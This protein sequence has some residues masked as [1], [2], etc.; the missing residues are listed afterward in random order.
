MRHNLRFDRHG[1]LVADRAGRMNDAQQVPVGS[2][3]ANPPTAKH[4]EPG[5]A[6]TAACVGA[7]LARRPSAARQARLEVLQVDSK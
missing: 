3:V 1:V 5:H 6:L 4:S 7:P 2:S